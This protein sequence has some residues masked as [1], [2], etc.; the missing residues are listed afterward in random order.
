MIVD[1]LGRISE[2]RLDKEN[3]LLEYVKMGN[4]K[5]ALA[6]L[7]QILQDI[8][9]L[10]KGSL[11]DCQVRISEMMVMVWRTARQVGLIEPENSYIY[12]NYLQKLTKCQTYAAL[13]QCCEGFLEEVF[14]K[15]TSSKRMI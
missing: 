13:K 1:F 4:Y 3:I 11:I 8:F 5:E 12:S 15:Q 6:V 2:Y 10:G 9:V 7:D 14:Q